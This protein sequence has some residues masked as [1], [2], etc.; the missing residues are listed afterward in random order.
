M[1]EGRPSF[2]LSSS[3]SLKRQAL[4]GLDMVVEQLDR[5]LEALAAS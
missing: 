3:P 5:T 1:A 2:Q 4:G